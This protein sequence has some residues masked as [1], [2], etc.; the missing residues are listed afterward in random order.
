MRRA[1][2]A[3]MAAAAPAPCASIGRP[4][5]PRCPPPSAAQ[6]RARHSRS[7]DRGGARCAH[8]RRA[9]SSICPA[10]REKYPGAW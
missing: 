6:S 7:S 1:S 9:P 8:S 2:A 4:R 3:A 10:T 5:S